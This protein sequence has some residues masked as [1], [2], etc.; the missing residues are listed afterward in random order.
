MVTRIPQ[1]FRLVA[2]SRQFTVGAALGAKSETA[3]SQPVQDPVKKLFLDKIKVAIQ[4][5][6]AKELRVY[7]VIR[8]QQEILLFLAPKFMDWGRGGN[9]S[10]LSNSYISVA[11]S[12]L[13]TF[14]HD[15][16]SIEALVQK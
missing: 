4:L 6:T 9:M 16:S 12:I 15:Y 11:M 2:L 7:F 3:K 14:R 5:C 1:S 10:P 8:P 13:S